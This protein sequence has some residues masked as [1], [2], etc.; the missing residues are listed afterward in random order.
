MSLHINLAHISDYCLGKT[1]NN[2][3]ISPQVIK[4]SI[5]IFLLLS[6]RIYFSDKQGFLTR[7]KDSKKEDFYIQLFF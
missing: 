2:E 4:D 6:N 3:I 1:P 5:A 7:Q